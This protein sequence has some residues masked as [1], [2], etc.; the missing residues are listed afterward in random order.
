MQY[1][2]RRY[3][4]DLF[5][6]LGPSGSKV[7]IVPT[8]NTFPAPSDEWWANELHRTR[9]GFGAMAEKFWI[10]LKSQSAKIPC[11]DFHNFSVWNY[12]PMIR[13]SSYVLLGRSSTLAFWYLLKKGGD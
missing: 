2:E 5:A 10:A 4:A 12:P 6:S 1:S 7:F 3:M 8:Q 13:A 9:K 11:A